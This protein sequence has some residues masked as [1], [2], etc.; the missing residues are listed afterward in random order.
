MNPPVQRNKPTRLLAVGLLT[1]GSAVL[2]AEKPDL[3]KLDLSKLPPPAEQQGVTYAKDIRP[4]FE[5]SCF[6][7]HGENRPKAG[8]RLDSLEGVLKGSKD[9]AVLVPGTSEKSLV[10]IAVARLDDDLA[11]PPK[12]RPGRG[13]PGGPGR[14]DGFGGPGGRPPG[15][16]GIP[17]A[18]TPPP[19]A[20]GGGPRGGFGPPP[21]PLTAA[22]VGLV[23]AWVNQ[24]AK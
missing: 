1:L 7:C 14:P 24:G 11:M 3:S 18:A 10:V 2:A 20:G 12:F 4:L 23:R 17:D 15:R 16:P 9:G 5:A 21:K 19:P 8:L 13:G 6:R 22:Q